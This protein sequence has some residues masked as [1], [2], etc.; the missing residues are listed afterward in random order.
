P[1]WLVAIFDS[2]QSEHSLRRNYPLIG[3]GRWLAELLRPFVRQYFIE[4]ETDG[5]PINRMFR[6]IVYQRA[7]GD[8]DTNP[9]GTKVDTYHDGYEWLGHSL[10]ATNV[11]EISSDPRVLVGG[12]E[13][14][15]P[16]SASILNISAM[17][18]GALSNAAIRALNLG[19]KE[20]NFFHNTGEG[21]LSPYHLEHGGDVVWQ[22]GT[23]YF[24]C[25]TREGRFEPS[26]FEEKASHDSVR[27]IELKLSQGAKPGHGGILPASKNT[28]EIARIRVVEAGTDVISPSTHPEFST[29]VGLLEFIQKLRE[30]SGGKPVGFKLC[31]GRRSE[32][33]GICK[34]MKQTGIRPDFI[35]V[36][37]G[38]GGTGAAP[39]E[40]SNSVGMPLR[41]ALAFVDDCLRGYSLRDDIRVIAA[42]KIITSFHMAKNLALGAD[43]CNSA[44]GM[45]L[46]LGCVQSLVC[47]TN[48]CP[49]GVATQDPQLARGLVVEDKYKRVHRFH[50]E[51]VHALVD[52]LSSAGI[53]GP[54]ELN[55]SHIFRR[56]NQHQVMRYD[57]IFPDI[58]VGAFEAAPYPESYAELIEHAS[59]EHFH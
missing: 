21:G 2:A 57:E 24:G 49:T 28:P 29:P 23:G 17:S 47:H 48:R 30:L 15:H 27:M 6:S 43:M 25:R 8:I 42:G 36:D 9:Y 11:E 33:I 5:A 46:A 38:E 45:M 37:G 59:A 52:L 41:E 34:A 53:S 40:Y 55:R 16:Y 20:G 35:T 31:I 51:T 1:L 26:L 44:R 12:D 58:E 7:K 18:F 10:S 13:C 22:V 4:S 50:K 32:F 56:V 54:K 14:K 3:R 39:L 19:A